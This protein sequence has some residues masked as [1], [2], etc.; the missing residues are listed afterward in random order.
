[1]TMQMV[2]R[3]TCEYVVPGSGTESLSYPERVIF[4]FG[5][6]VSIDVGSLCYTVRTIPKRDTRRLGRKVLLTSLSEARRP[7]VR[8]LIRHMSLMAASSGLRDSTLRDR[9]SR[10]VVFISW[11]DNNNWPDVLSSEANARHAL[12]AYLSYIRDRVA[13][14]DLS[15]NAGAKQQEIVTRVYEEFFETQDIGR[16]LNLLRKDHNSA[17]PRIPPSEQSQGRVLSLCEAIFDGICDLTLHNKIYPY[18]LQVPKYLKLPSDVLWIFPANSWFKRPETIEDSQ[19][20]KGYNYLE[21]RV[22]TIDELKALYPGGNRW[23]DA[24]RNIKRTMNS[25]NADFNHST[26][27]NLAQLAQNVY[28]ILLIAVTGLNWSQ[29]ISLPWADNFETSSSRQGFRT[30]K[31]RAKGKL[32]SFEL[33]ALSLPRF[34]RYL[35][36]RRYLLQGENYERLFFHRESPKN[37]LRDFHITFN[38]IFKVLQRIDPGLELIT[39]GEW[40]AAKSDWLIRNTD[41][42]TTALVLQNTERVVLRHYIEGS[43]TLHQEEMSNFLVSMSSVVDKSDGSIKPLTSRAV[44]TCT[45]FGNPASIDVNQAAPPNCR[46][47]EGCLFC[48]KFRVHADVDDTRKLLSCRYALSLMAP[49]TDSLEDY[50]RYLQPLLSRIDNI[51]FEISRIN[52]AMV[53][54][55]KTEVESDGVLDPYWANKVQM[56]LFLGI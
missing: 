21:G 20:G 23:R 34:R 43:E 42:S 51:V 29:V 49:T 38:T 7:H 9:Y 6:T 48:D 18:P 27:W 41:L 15:L 13:R 26:R 5:K 30:I 8:R 36:L 25:A 40:R 22:A 54:R 24:A 46:E 16:K 44:G 2:V 12:I 45:S 53:A 33:P 4:R 3:E 37:P 47:A 10:F 31:W 28:S 17:R 14:N 39:A 32:V 56:M 55:I 19:Y 50:S 52:P 1:M 35:L 11:A